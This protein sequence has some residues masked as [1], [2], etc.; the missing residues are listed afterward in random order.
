VLRVKPSYVQIM[1]VKRRPVMIGERSGE[2]SKPINI[3][4]CSATT[5]VS[6]DIL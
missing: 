1:G 5:I 2:L 3:C 4:K 6:L